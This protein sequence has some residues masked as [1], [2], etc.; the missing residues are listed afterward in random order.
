MNI[1]P[2]RLMLGPRVADRHEVYY[3]KPARVVA[4]HQPA[5]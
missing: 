3:Y 2:A 1:M 5:S 4:R